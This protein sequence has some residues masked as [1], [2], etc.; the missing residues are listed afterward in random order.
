MM[1]IS[2]ILSFWLGIY[3]DNVL[4]SAYGLRKPWYF[5]CSPSYWFGSNDEDRSRVH[6]R[7]SK[8]DMADDNEALFEVKNMKKENFEP[9]SRELLV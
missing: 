4:P 2:L 3:F 9:V 6:Q 5:C 1:T 7:D 8:A